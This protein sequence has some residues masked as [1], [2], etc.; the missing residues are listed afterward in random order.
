MELT[1]SNLFVEFY[2]SGTIIRFGSPCPA[3]TTKGIADR[4]E[5][6]EEKQTMRAVYKF[7]MNPTGWPELLS[8]FNSIRIRLS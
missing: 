8:L 4:E 5:L 3:A 1:R 7:P 6:S 2:R